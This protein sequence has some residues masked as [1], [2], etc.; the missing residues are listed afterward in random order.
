MSMEALKQ[1]VAA[2]GLRLI[3]VA[4]LAGVDPTVLSKIVNGRRAAPERVK[5]RIARVLGKRV[6]E[7]FPVDGQAA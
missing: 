5:G 2:A 1:A 6:K 4:D 3:D 7:L